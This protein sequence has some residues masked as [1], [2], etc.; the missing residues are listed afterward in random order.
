MTPEYFDIHAHTHF[1]AFKEDRDEVIKRALDNNTWLINIGTQKETSK[2]AVVLAHK[3][4]KGVYASIGLHPIHTEKCHDD[5]MESEIDVCETEFDY[6]FYKKLA[7]DDKVVA[8]G[9]CGLDFFHLEENTKAKQIE[10]FKK[11]IELSIEVNKPLMLH[12]RDAYQEVLDILKEYKKVN[13]DN[14]RGNVHFFAGNIEV[15]KEFLALG[16]S[17]SFTGVVT[18]PKSKKIGMA[19]YEEIIKITPIDRLMSETDAPYVAPAPYRGKRN[20]PLYVKEVVAKIAEIKG[21]TVE[22]VSKQLVDNAIKT[23]NIKD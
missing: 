23:F 10:I 16:F 4:P 17:L 6:D 8:I 3:Y 12:V 1:P 13:K 22:E 9:E 20:E 14:L 18:Y 11:H 5:D 15:A 2:E 7:Q 21:I 19:D